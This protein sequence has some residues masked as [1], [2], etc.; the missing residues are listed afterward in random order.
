VTRPVQEP[1]AARDQ[2]RVAYVARQLQRRPVSVAKR[3]V[4][5]FRATSELSTLVV[6]DS[7]FWFGATPDMDGMVLT[8]AIAYVA[9]PSTLGDVTLQIRRSGPALSGGSDMLTVPLTIP[10]GEHWSTYGTPAEYDVDTLTGEY[11]FVNLD[12]DDAGTD[13]AGLGAELHFSL[14]AA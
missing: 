5:A 9:V 14:P 10:E 12:V 8:N 11:S 13:V 3:V 1:T 7:V 2:Q 6:A 4:I